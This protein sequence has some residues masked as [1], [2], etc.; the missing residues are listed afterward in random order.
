[1]KSRRQ[2]LPVF[3]AVASLF[4]KNAQKHSCKPSKEGDQLDCLLAALA[5]VLDDGPL[6]GR[7]KSIFA[8]IE[9]I[10]ALNSKKIAKAV[11]KSI[12]QKLKAQK[13]RHY[14][15]RDSFCE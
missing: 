5:W 14:K 2:I 13:P 12:N 15:G 11:A 1:M 7:W 10:A 8:Q 9:A 6:P 4:Q 3:M